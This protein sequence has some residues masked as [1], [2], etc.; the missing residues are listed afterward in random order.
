MRV[1][2]APREDRSVLPLEHLGLLSVRT[3]D[4]YLIEVPSARKD[5][6]KVSVILTLSAHLLTSKC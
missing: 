2:V 1:C 3:G 5:V 4:G 6:P